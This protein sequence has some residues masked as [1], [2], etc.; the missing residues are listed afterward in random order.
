MTIM[1][2]TQDEIKDDSFNK[3]FHKK[4]IVLRFTYL[5]THKHNVTIS[6]IYC[7]TGN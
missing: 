7:Q 1:Q 2:K 3:H 6:W 4:N 5:N